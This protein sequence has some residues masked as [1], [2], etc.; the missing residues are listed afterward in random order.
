ME[1]GYQVKAK[2]I[3]EFLNKTFG[4]NYKLWLKSTYELDNST[5]V[6]M[7][8][9]DGEKR[10][11]FKNYFD[12]ENIVEESYEEKTRSLKPIR[13][14]FQIVEKENSK[15][16]VYLG[17]YTLNKEK[18]TKEKRIFSPIKDVL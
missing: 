11:T 12:N 9:I 15:T 1:I 2:T 8:K 16:F 7:I 18:S 6:W 17:N 5:T 4:T 10:N 14:V 13:M 3:A